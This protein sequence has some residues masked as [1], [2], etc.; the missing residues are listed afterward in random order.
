MYTKEKKKMKRNRKPLMFF[1]PHPLYLYLKKKI[2]KKKKQKDPYLHL[3]QMQGSP[4]AM[5][6]CQRQP[7]NKSSSSGTIR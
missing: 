3:I 5:F 2:K 7:S 1:P 4:H 6:Q